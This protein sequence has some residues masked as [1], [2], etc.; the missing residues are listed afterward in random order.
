MCFVLLECGQEGGKVD[1]GQ[2]NH[3]RRELQC[4]QC[5]LT[6][7][8]GSSALAKCE[9]RTNYPTYQW[10]GAMQ[11]LSTFS[12]LGCVSSSQFKQGERDCIKV[13]TFKLPADFDHVWV[14]HTRSKVE[15][16]K[17]DNQPLDGKQPLSILLE[18]LTTNPYPLAVALVARKGAL[19]PSHVPSDPCQSRRRSTLTLR[20]VPGSAR[21]RRP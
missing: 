21:N 17:F 5:S 7:G 14:W 20:P 13:Q 9:E 16:D 11:T 4:H 19:A 15:T 12:M 18:N 8:G 10:S 1:T 3:M 2:S 6:V